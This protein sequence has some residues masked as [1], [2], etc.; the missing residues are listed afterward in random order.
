MNAV[1]CNCMSSILPPLIFT[2]SRFAEKLPSPL[3]DVLDVEALSARL[4][5]PFDEELL[6]EHANNKHAEKIIG[7][8]NLKHCITIF[9]FFRI[10]RPGVNRICHLL[11]KFFFVL[12][13]NK[14]P[15]N[16]PFIPH[17]FQEISD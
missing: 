11:L 14:A 10:R 1:F 9:L 5:L 4:S 13:S 3:E 2:P 17:G 15:E 7:E 8:N 6:A 12:G 16:V